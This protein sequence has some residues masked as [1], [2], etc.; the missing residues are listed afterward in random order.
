LSI[1][2]KKE[3]EKIERKKGGEIKRKKNSAVLERRD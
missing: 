2:K 3:K 1:L